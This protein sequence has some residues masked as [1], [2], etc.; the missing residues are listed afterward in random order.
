M[1]RPAI[2]FFLFVLF[3]EYRKYGTKKNSQPLKQNVTILFPLHSVYLFIYF[4][5]TLN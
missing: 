4:I 1:F 3:P 5:L 2:Y